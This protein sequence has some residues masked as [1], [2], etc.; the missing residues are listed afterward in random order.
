LIRVG[1]LKILRAED[2]AMR[3]LVDVGNCIAWDL[4]LSQP[5]LTRVIWVLILSA[6]CVPLTG[7]ATGEIPALQTTWEELES[8]GTA[9]AALQLTNPATNGEIEGYASAASVNRG[10]D[11][12]L[13]VNTKEPSYTLD[14]FRI[15]WY[16][17]RAMRRM[18][19][20]IR[21]AGVANRHPILTPPRD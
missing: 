8:G 12:K 17:G 21:L 14:V 18:A 16:N 7:C 4:I 2:I 19:S 6:A 5:R 13:F 9:L 10:E 15:G 20:G 3:W 11:I 1:E